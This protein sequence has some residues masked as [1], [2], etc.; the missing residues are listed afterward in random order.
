MITLDQLTTMFG[1]ALNG[2]DVTMDIR[3]KYHPRELQAILGEA[4]ADL[5]SIDPSMASDMAIDYV[6]TVV[7][8]SDVYTATLAKKTI[9]SKGIFRIKSGGDEFAIASRE[10]YRQ[11]STVGT[12]K[13]CELSQGGTLTFSQRPAGFPSVTVTMIPAFLEMDGDEVVIMAG[14][15]VKLF[16]LAFDM[17]RRDNFIQDK[18]NNSRVDGGTGQ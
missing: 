13:L 3:G 5:V 15:E 17:M 10:E 6:T 8:T 1:I 7:E 4:H 18:L 11:L 12:Q 14:N 9:G 2:S 16:K